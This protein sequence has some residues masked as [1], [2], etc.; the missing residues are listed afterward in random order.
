ME[1]NI[2]KRLG[3]GNNPNLI[4]NLLDKYSFL[5]RKYYQEL[6]KTMEFL[7]S[8]LLILPTST[9]GDLKEYIEID[10][11]KDVFIDTL[12]YHGK[13][14]K[15]I[16]IGWLTK[17][18][19]DGSGDY[20]H[21]CKDDESLLLKDILDHAHSF[22]IYFED[23][24][25]LI[26]FL[27]KF[28]ITHSVPFTIILE[29]KELYYKLLSIRNGEQVDTNVSNFNAEDIAWYGAVI[30]EEEYVDALNNL[31]KYISDVHKIYV[32]KYDETIKGAV[33]KPSVNDY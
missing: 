30:N 17:L 26:N 6:I 5:E 33:Y 10:D 16:M 15:S 24:N 25:A 29:I 11:W 4:I 8:E 1:K 18:K 19:P 2:I 3:T 7:A 20:Y 12:G 28:T 23:V 9:V 27:E 32:K 13:I 31:H 21:V 14:D 22:L